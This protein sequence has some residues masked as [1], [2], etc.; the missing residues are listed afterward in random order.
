MG[1]DNDVCNGITT[2]QS[3]AKKLKCVS[4]KHQMTLQK[5]NA[6]ITPNILQPYSMTQIYP[7]STNTE[8]QPAASS[9]KATQ[10]AV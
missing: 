7:Q 1:K 9:G 8:E 3:Q 6:T 5:Q 2:V 4:S 10:L